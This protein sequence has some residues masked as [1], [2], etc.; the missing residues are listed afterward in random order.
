MFISLL[1]P[2]VV[3]LYHHIDGKNESRV[4]YINQDAHSEKVF[5]KMLEM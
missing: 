1:F 5:R 2:Q 4:Q 3:Y